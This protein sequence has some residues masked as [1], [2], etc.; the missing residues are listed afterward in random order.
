MEGSPSI[1]L[2]FFHLITHIFARFVLRSHSCTANSDLRKSDP[3]S[4][5]MHTLFRRFPSG[6]ATHHWLRARIRK[7]TS[8]H[9]IC[10]QRIEMEF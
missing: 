10:Q 4:V 7:S 3:I 8:P 1:S 5:L 6:L 2:F 9:E